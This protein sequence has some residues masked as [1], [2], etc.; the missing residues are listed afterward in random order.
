MGA[1]NIVDVTS[2]KA[3]DRL[4]LGR[5]I[6]M[7]FVILLFLGTEGQ[8]KEPLDRDR[9]RAE[10]ILE[11][12]IEAR[13][14]RKAIDAEKVRY[15][16]GFS[17]DSDGTFI[18]DRYWVKRDGNYYYN[19]VVSNGTDIEAGSDTTI[20][21]M[22]D[23]LHPT[24]YEGERRDYKRLESAFDALADYRRLCTDW[25]L[26]GKCVIEDEICDQVQLTTAWGR[27]ELWSI[28]RTSHLLVQVERTWVVGDRRIESVCK[29]SDYRDVDGVQIPHLLVQSPKV[30]GK[31][32]EFRTQYT[33][34]THD[35][36]E[37][38]PSMFEVP[39]RISAL[40]APTAT[41]QPT[42]HR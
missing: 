18:R 14:G 4:R 12:A 24:I 28:D 25:K 20:Y 27:T 3:E 42:S 6:M 19:A 23:G 9:V 41:S 29:F 7:L 37:L 1:C 34:V 2:L 13:G 40:K 35:P 15:F 11:K 17:A 26:V 21:W 36:P 33:I 16:Q 5:V 10:S 8:S 31:R 32:Y 39:P 38:R 22:D 30:D